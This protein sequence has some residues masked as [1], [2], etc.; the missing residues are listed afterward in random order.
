MSDEISS[1]SPAR[2]ALRYP[3]FRRYVTAR[4]LSG[5]SSEMISVAVGWQIYGLTHRPLD[6]GLVGL[7][8]FAPAVLLFL[9]AGHTADRY[10]RQRILR[11]C[12]AA[13]SLC[14]MAL[15]ALTLRGLSSVW[16]IYAVLLGNGMV[17]AFNGPT[18]QAFMPQLVAPE[19][20]PNAVTWSSSFF[21]VAM[22]FGPM[23][24]GLIYGFADS[25]IPVYACALAAYLVAFALVSMIR[26]VLPARPR[27]P[28]SLRIVLEGLRYIH[29]N[30]IILGS[31]SLDLFAVLLGG[32]VAL[33][34]VYASEILKTGAIGLGILR[35]APGAGAVLMAISLAHFPIRRRAGL[36]MLY[37]V[38]GFGVFTIVFGLSHDLAL[39]LIALVLTGCLDMVSVVIRSTLVQLATPDEMRGRVS[40]VS[41]LFISA[42]NEIGQFESGIAAQWFG[43]VPAV[44]LGGVGT[45]AIV[46]LWAWLFPA[47]R[48]ADQ[49][50]PDEALSSTAPAD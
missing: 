11:F 16:P 15:L 40:A 25:P 4:F 2:A 6:L 13:F 46:L 8:Q 19:H 32:A 14:A 43:T 34:P 37:C 47:L 26:L 45:V 17:R 36:S 23:A 5:V 41:V 42:S 27:P 9:L 22:I 39:S 33:L 3:N 10:P 7:A 50:V 24:G 35:A 21:Q 12:Y 44:V 31:I 1:G 28:A 30:K 29:R 20:F 48:R 49:L 18:G 38:F